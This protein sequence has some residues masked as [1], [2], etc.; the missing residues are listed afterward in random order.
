[1]VLI[2]NPL[3]FSF[4]AFDNIYIYVPYKHGIY[5]YKKEDFKRKLSQKNKDL[6]SKRILVD[7]DY[8][9]KLRDF[10]SSNI[11]D[12]SLKLMY[13]ITTDQC[14]FRCRYCFIEG[15]YINKKRDI[16]KWSTAKKWINYFYKHIETNEPTAIFYGGEPLLNPEVVIK[17]IKLIR[18]W[19]K[20][21][22][23]NTRIGINTNGSV[24]SKELAKIFKKYNVT[25]AISLDGPP[26]LHN[27][28]RI[29]KGDIGT[30]DM[31]KK[32]I[33]R[34]HKAGVEISLSIT[35]S[36]HN[37]HFL[38]HIARWV[39][40]NFPFIKSVGFNPPL[41]S[42]MFKNNI[43]YEE[44]MFN[45]Y[46]AYRIFRYNKVYEDRIMRRI[47]P[48]IKEFPYLKDCAGCG[49]Q[50]VLAPNGS[51]GS[52][53]AFLGTKKFF[54]NV[55]DVNNFDFKKESIFVMWNK[56]TPVNKNEC[57]LC[58]FQLICGNACPYSAY[59]FTTNIFSKDIRMC[60]MMPI[61][62]KELLI[63]AYYPKIK[64]IFLD[65]DGVLINTDVRSAILKLNKKYNLKL[66]IPNN[67]FSPKELFKNKKNWKMLIK[68]YE[69]LLEKNEYVNASLVRQL[70]YI[71][72]KFRVKIYIASSS[73]RRRIKEK[74]DK[75]HVKIVDG[76]FSIKKEKK[77]IIKLLKKL[78]IQPEEA[79]YIGDSFQ[80]DIKPFYSVGIRC[81]QFHIY[82]SYMDND[83][84]IDLINSYNEA[85]NEVRKNI[86]NKE[87]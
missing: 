37:Y 61:F 54:I 58:S 25:L 17:S 9:K 23:I 85:G 66:E 6:M 31:V 70:K 55:K 24:F 36:E 71:K 51:I 34:Y 27:S 84:F 52:C 45:M 43:D 32:N 1:M 29:N 7:R 14:N 73:P 35:I 74:I 20:K 83:W 65:L 3:M 59:M 49:N 13:I 75:Y 26:E 76:F 81:V 56:I 18:K 47:I 16:L 28:M 68:E 69:K 78:S 79:L 63:D 19:D 40:D 21:L 33:E 8:V 53:H 10:Y 44:I 57:A 15:N 72:K 60:K 4:E 5:K 2:K 30:F 39:I 80:K 77:E 82:T 11:G 38:P 42:L 46:N 67:F 48:I 64:Y 12:P 86:K 41:D 87:L 62:M 50:I 22:G